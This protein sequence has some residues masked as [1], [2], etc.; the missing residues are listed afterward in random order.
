MAR[1]GFGGR[2]L[3][4]LLLL[5]AAASGFATYRWWLQRGSSAQLAAAGARTEGGA[6]GATAVPG[7]TASADAPDSEGAPT[8]RPVPET[9]P[10]IRLQDLNGQMHALRDYSGR[11]LLVNFW[12]TW[13]APCR[14][15]IPLL[16]KLRQ[17]HAAQRV[18][19]LGIA[20]DF[21]DAVAEYVKA[22]PIGYPLLVGEQD[23]LDAAQKFGMELVLPFTVFVDAQGRIIA[24]KV[25]ELHEEEAETI[26]AAMAD[27]AAGKLDL[28]AVRARIGAK[29]KDFAAKRAL[30]AQ[31]GSA[32][33][34]PARLVGAD[35]EDGEH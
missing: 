12:A 1:P 21:K 34:D 29:L 10:D 17:R 5:A 19:V 3:P 9:L 31:A 6:S 25:G 16:Q 2:L 8:P 18:E 20:V 35:D 22:T 23:G 14:R 32:S 24:M 28:P 26:L 30:A 33:V 27:L 7:T 11:P 15:E 4:L 13:C